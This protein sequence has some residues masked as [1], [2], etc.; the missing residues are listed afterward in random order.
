M[1]ALFAAS[2]LVEGKPCGW[3]S[4]R[5]RAWLDTDQRSLWPPAVAFEQPARFVD[6][7]EWA[8]DVPMFFVY[9]GGEYR[10]PGMTFRRFMAD[11]FPGERAR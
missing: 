6:Y 5:A 7:A 10:P 1:T 8:L 3:Q 11:G 4:Y 9:R 2:P